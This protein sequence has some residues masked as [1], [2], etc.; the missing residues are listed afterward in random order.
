MRPLLPLLFALL[1]LCG[2]GAWAQANATLRVKDL[3]K[4]QGWRE[5]VLVGSGI[6][7]GLAGTV[8]FLLLAIWVF[9]RR[10]L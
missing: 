4:L 9:R 6:V 5:N 2:E 3:G 1:L 7:T 8:V 10:D